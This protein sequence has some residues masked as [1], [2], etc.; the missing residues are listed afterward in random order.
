MNMDEHEQVICEKCGGVHF[1]ATVFCGTET[2]WEEELFLHCD[3]CGTVIEY[4]ID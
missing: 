1:T 3:G 4:D 2:G